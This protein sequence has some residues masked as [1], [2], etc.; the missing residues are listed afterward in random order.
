MEEE[1]EAGEVV[2]EYAWIIV[3][4]SPDK[5]K[6]LRIINGTC[7]ANNETDAIRLGIQDID[8][9]FADWKL[10]AFEVIGRS[11]DEEKGDKFIAF[12]ASVGIAE[13]ECERLFDKFCEKM[14]KDSR[15]ILLV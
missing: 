4:F 13:H 3:G 7:D 10:F 5:P 9:D 1:N 2:H 8:S 11:S 12:L 15:E 6:N 14:E